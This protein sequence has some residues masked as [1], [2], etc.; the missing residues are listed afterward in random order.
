M[1]FLLILM[2]LFFSFSAV[3]QA[4]EWGELELD[5]K[6]ILNQEILFSNEGIVISPETQFEVQDI[7]GL[8]IDVELYEVRMKKCAFPTKTAEM[9]LLEPFQK[10]DRSVGIVLK[11]NCVLEIFVELKDIYSKSLFRN[12]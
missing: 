4:L 12:N 9:I 2:C 3:A 5:Q 8:P 10:N 6:L 7:I 11:E 1:K